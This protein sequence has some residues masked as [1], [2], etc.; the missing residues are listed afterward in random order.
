MGL[1]EGDAG[2]QWMLGFVHC[3][4]RHSAPDSAE[5]DCRFLGGFTV[6]ATEAVSMLLTTNGFDLFKL[7]MTYLFL[8]VSS[9]GPSHERAGTNP[10]I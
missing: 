4:V 9:C 10:T 1:S 3:S 5:I 8:T 6:L 7:W 2:C